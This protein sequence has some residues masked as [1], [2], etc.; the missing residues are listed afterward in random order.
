MKYRKLWIGAIV[1]IGIVAGVMAVWLIVKPAP[2][3]AT[4]SQSAADLR[5]DPN[6][7]SLDEASSLWVVVNKHRPLNPKEYVPEGLRVPNVPLR[8][9]GDDSM[10]L[11]P[12][13]GDA[14]EG[15]FAAAKAEGVNLMLASGYRSY[16]YQVSLYNRYLKE[17]GQVA[18]DATSAR[19][20]YSEHQTGLAADI[21]PTGKNC[22]IEVC[23]ADT[24][25]GKWLAANAY[26]YG[27]VIR[28]AKDKDSIT[29]YSYEP[30]HIRY[31]GKGLA[32]EMRKKG[33]D[34]LEEFFGLEPAPSYN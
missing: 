29:G 15:M 30:W 13:T 31:V 34:T 10:Q 7:Y 25:E 2:Q 19:P 28:Y 11:G 5:F 20:G 22:E 8:F 12:V 27:F 18:T 23:F 17:S 21:E 6:R 14:L 32:A 26:K 3:A 4:D 9:P 33:V 16:N 24:P 1:V